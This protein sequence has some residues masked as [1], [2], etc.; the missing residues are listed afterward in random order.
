M[1]A[2]ALRPALGPFGAAEPLLPALVLPTLVLPA[3]VLTALRLTAL[4]LAALRLTALLLAALIAAIGAQDAIVML[5]VLEIIF[6]RDI[7]S[8]RG[9]VAC[10]REIFFQDLVDGSANANLGTVTFEHLGTG[11]VAVVRSSGITPAARML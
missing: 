4:L 7:V 6:R 10:Q 2:F 5:R 3:L 11:C 8:G 9:S 1:A